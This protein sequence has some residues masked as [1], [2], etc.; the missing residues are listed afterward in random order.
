MKYSDFK[1]RAEHFNGTDWD[2]SRE[3][4]AIYKFIDDPTTTTTAMQEVTAPP[5]RSSPGFGSLKHL[6]G[7]GLDALS[8]HS[9]KQICVRSGK[10]WAEDVDKHF[11]NNDYLMFSNIYYAHPGVRADLTNWGG[12]MIWETGVHGF[13]LDAAQHFSWTFARDWIA[14]VQAV[15]RQKRGRNA[16][17]VGEILSGE[18]KKQ[19]SWLDTV[20]PPGSTV[21]VF[22][23]D[24]PLL[25]SFSRVSEDIRI[26]SK[27]AD[28]R[29][30]LKGP[31][32]FNDKQALVY[33]RP[34]QAVTSVANHDTQPG[35]MS[36]L[37]MQR[38]HKA[39]FYAFILL[40]DEGFPCVFWGDLVGTHGPKA[41]P[42]VRELR[43][44]M[45]ARKM[46]AYGNQRD[47]FDQ[48]L[49][50]GWTR[51]GIHD[52]PGCAVLL[53]IGAPGHV[54]RKRMTIGRPGQKWIDIL[55]TRQ[56]AQQVAIDASGQAAFACTALGVAVYVD[57]AHAAALNDDLRECEARA[58]A[59]LDHL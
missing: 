7:N 29:T 11:G 54:A 20:S 16:F 48:A 10:G 49:C 52:R 23:F 17:V 46:F 42:R 9:S 36:F 51:S 30:F 19:I 58:A 28:L 34:T 1:W 32:G 31:A 37:P 14:A 3:K 6:I 18:V 53:S 13:R 2:Q 4:H 22:A 38:S 33:L 43:S 27:N 56:D 24:V 45:L 15:S 47:Y 44:L 12:W 26:G 8:A 50:I 5:P 25:E 57:A 41:E 40:R 35:Q 39:M 59:F 55:S 21:P